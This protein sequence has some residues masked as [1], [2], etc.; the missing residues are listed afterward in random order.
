MVAS[1]LIPEI[2]KVCDYELNGKVLLLPIVGTGKSTI[3]LSKCF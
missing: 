2:T 1:G 3:I